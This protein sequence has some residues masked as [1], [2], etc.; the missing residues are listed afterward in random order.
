ML[1]LSRTF[2]RPAAP[3]RL[4]YGAVALTFGLLAVSAASAQPAPG[5][6]AEACALVP[7]AEIEQIVGTKLVD[8][9]KKTRMQN[10][11]VLS[12][13]DYESAGGGQVGVLI[14]RN[15]VKYVPGSEKA[16]FEKQGMKIRYVK[17]IGTTAFFI[18]M[19][20]MGTGMSVFRG[21][22]DYVQ[23]SAMAVSTPEKVSPAVEKLTRLVLER[24]K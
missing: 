19:F 21:D 17:G 8:G 10:P 18:D 13:C 4:T 7:K 9:K 1:F 15:A 11:G 24:W 23:V 3:R 6:G 14:R 12:S 16:E 5:K 2:T 22:Y 20:G